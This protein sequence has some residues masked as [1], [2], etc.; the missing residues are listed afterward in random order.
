MNHN[1]LHVIC[2]SFHHCLSKASSPH[3]SALL[4]TPRWPLV[5]TGNG[6]YRGIQMVSCQCSNKNC[7]AVSFPHDFWS[8]LSTPMLT[9][10]TSFTSHFT[11]C[12]NPSRQLSCSLSLALLISFP[13]LTIQRILLF[14]SHIFIPPGW[15]LPVLQLWWLFVFIKTTTSIPAARVPP[16]CQVSISTIS[17]WI[18]H[19]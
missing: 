17:I 16:A 4:Y 12:G 3:S 19:L 1:P 10:V 15:L 6:S 2:F 7:E 5:I 13:T 9:H 11:H 18:F 14:V 8:Q